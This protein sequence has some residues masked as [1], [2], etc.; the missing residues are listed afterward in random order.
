MSSFSKN[1]YKNCST[2][3]RKHEKTPKPLKPFNLPPF[4][5]LIESE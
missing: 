4:F 1:K 3:S 2:E 5:T